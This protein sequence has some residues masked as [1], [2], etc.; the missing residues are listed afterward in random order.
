MRIN[1]AA[2][3][4]WDS[5]V[6][7]LHADGSFEFDGLP[8]GSYDIFTSV[9]GYEP[10]KQLRNVPINRDIDGMIIALEPKPRP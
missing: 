3:Q 6:A 1:I 4:A 8:P 10:A 2:D 7:V 9:R 5:Q